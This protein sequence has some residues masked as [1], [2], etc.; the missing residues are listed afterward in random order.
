VVHTF[1]IHTRRHAR[2]AHQVYEPGFQN[3]SADAAQYILA[4]FPF[5]NDGINAPPEQKLTQQKPRWAAPDYDDLRPHTF[6]QL[7]VS[8]SY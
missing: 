8:G 2:F 4:G 6:L 7:A 1:C 3:A 5:K